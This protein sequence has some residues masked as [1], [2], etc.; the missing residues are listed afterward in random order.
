M[1]TRC[2]GR[3]LVTDPEVEH[4]ISPPQEERC[5]PCQHLLIEVIRIEQGLAE[6]ELMTIERNR[7]RTTAMV[8]AEELRGVVR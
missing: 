6:L 4:A 7:W 2:N 5:E 8:L 1:V 3:W